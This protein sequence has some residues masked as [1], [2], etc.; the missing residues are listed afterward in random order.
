[1]VSVIISTYKGSTVIVDCV[2][3]VL[4]QT[5]KNIE[6]IVVDDN[7]KGT[8]EQIKTENAL[9]YLISNN[10]I[11]YFAEEK[12]HNASVA[13]NIGARLAKGKYISFLDDDD[14]YFDDKISRQVEA[15][16]NNADYEICYCG[17]KD[18][19]QGKGETI[20]RAQSY[21]NFTF[22]FLMMRVDV[23][24]STLFITKRIFDEVTGFNESFVR[25]QDWEFIARLSLKSGII[26]VD[27]IGTEKHTQNI[28]KRFTA[29]QSEDFRLYFI[30]NIPDVLSSLSKKKLNKFYTLTYQ[31]LAKLYLREHNFKRAFYFLIKSKRPISFFFNVAY[32]NIKKLF[33]HS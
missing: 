31:E 17:L 27:Y 19:V 6:C 2:N 25:H 26:G 24:T 20:Y 1:M 22:D 21:Q 5:Y 4:N 9:R 12:N 23:C 15:L 7:G 8:E 18:I 3:S 30:S 13:R 11:I 33:V 10:K 16:E 28:L 14:N 32:K 29:K